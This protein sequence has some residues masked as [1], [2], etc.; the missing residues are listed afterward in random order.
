MMRQSFRWLMMLMLVSLVLVPVVAQDNAAEDGH[1]LLELLGFVPAE[2]VAAES[3]FDLSYV[4]FRA[5][6]A[7]VGI[8][9][10]PDTD[11]GG[12]DFSNW[13]NQSSRLVAGPSFLPDVFIRQDAMREVVG[14]TVFDIDRA[15]MFGAP[16]SN[17]TVLA[18]DPDALTDPLVLGEKFRELGFKAQ[19]VDGGFTL[20]QHSERDGFEVDI[21][22]RDP[23]NPF[24]GQ[25]GRAEPVAMTPGYLLNSADIDTV[26]A[27]IDSATDANSLALSD[28]PE[29]VALVEAITQDSPLIQAH[30]LSPADVGFIPGD[31]MAIIMGQDA[32]NVLADYGPLPVYSMGVL[33]DTQDGDNAV[34]MAALV[35]ADAEDA[36]IAAEELAQ[37]VASQRLPLNADETVLERFGATVESAVYESANGF[38]VALARVHYPPSADTTVVPG[39]MYNN[40]VRSLWMREFFLFMLEE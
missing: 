39:L 24:G 40:W 33:A 4:D 12:D 23:A 27:M 3:F 25:L 10:P 2:M 21:E 14:F 37:R 38:T 28:L 8:A 32:P 9:R 15:L 7:A 20:W 16:P 34:H 18:G 6:E 35:Y 26:Q 30:F 31:P 19:D 1:P 11:L 17:G 22:N 5:F 29:F 36:A 13:V